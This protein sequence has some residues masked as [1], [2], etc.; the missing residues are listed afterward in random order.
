VHNWKHSA[1]SLIAT[2]LCTGLISACGQEAAAPAQ[3]IQQP[4]SSAEPFR[5]P[6][7]LNEVMVALVNHSAD[8]IWLAA[9]RSPE[10]DQDWRNLERMAYQLQIAGA[11]LVV[12]GN[13]PM[14]ETW[15][16]DPQWVAWA[17]KLEAAGDRAVKAV[18]ARDIT[19]IS[20]AG[21]EIV[22]VCEG[23]HFAFKPDLPTSGKFGELSPTAAD[24][25]GREEATTDDP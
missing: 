6:V 20:S 18:A 7:S 3:E 19:R 12:P 24:F 23:C 15:T 2:L 17:N 10:T 8:P 4:A 25:D 9:W 16:A 11:L 14:D 5:L 13:G 21:D 1:N 22:E